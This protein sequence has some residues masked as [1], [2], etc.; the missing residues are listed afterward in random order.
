MSELRA[1]AS[2]PRD[3]G[4]APSENYFPGCR[5]TA[6]DGEY[7][8]RRSAGM[9]GYRKEPAKT[10]GGD[11]PDGWPHRD[12]LDIVTRRLSAGGG[13]LAELINA[14][15]NTSPANIE[16]TIPGPKLPSG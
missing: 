9:K 10:A 8:V 3:G 5:Q 14:A 12:V 6:E 11:R 16:N 1:T 4:W 13:P 7:L 15:G 2:H